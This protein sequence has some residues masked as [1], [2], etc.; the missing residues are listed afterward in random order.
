MLVT[1]PAF[2]T[3]GHNYALEVLNNQ[4]ERDHEA[5]QIHRRTD[6][7]L[8]LCRAESG[9]PVANIFRPL[10][11]A[12]RHFTFGNEKYTSLGATELRDLRQ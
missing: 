10:G 6:H 4:R 3:T 9:A 8:A 2:L 7:S 11:V 5:F 12:R 1:C